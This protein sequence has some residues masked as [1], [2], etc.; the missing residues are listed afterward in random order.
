MKNQ[1]NQESKLIYSHMVDCIDKIK[2][3]KEHL[4]GDI[5][6]PETK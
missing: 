1:G 6:E 4:F 3:T 5:A 2:K